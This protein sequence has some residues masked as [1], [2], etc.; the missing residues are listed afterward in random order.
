[1]SED[2]RVVKTKEYIKNAFLDLLKEKKY[3][4]V[5][6]KEISSLAKINRNTFYLHYSSKDDLVS[7]L[8]NEVILK[9]SKYFFSVLSRISNNLEELPLSSYIMCTHLIIDALNKEIEFYEVINNDPDLK[10]YMSHLAKTLKLGL[11]QVTHV[12]NLDDEIRFEYLFNGFF[13]V[14]QHYFN[15]PTIPLEPLCEELGTLLYR[16]SITKRISSDS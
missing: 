3:A 1:M 8:V 7:S 11:R 16:T 4:K 2:L 5:S 10:F 12:K 14:I 6:V 13:G 15:N 9:Q